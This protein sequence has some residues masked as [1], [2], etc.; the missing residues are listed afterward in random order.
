[1]IFC[2]ELDQNFSTKKEMI[3]ALVAHKQELI[4][5]KKSF[6]KTANNPFFLYKTAATKAA[7]ERELKIGDTVEAVINT[8]LVFDHHQDVHLLGIW[9]KT[10][11]EQSGKIFHLTD[12][13]IRLGSVVGYPKDVTPSVMPLSWRQLRQEADGYTEGLVFN[14]VMTDKTNPDAFKA[15]RDNEPVQHSIRMEYVNLALAVDDP[16][17][18]E[19]YALYQKI[20]P[21]IFNRQDVDEYG[22]FWAVSEAKISR[23]GSI[24][25]FGSNEITP[26]LSKIST[27]F[28]PH[29]G[30]GSEPQKFNVSEAI[31]K[32][33]ILN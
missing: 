25:L 9:N 30:T 28:Q 6:I 16:D 20:Y 3:K 5:L 27:P 33:T 4:G 13:D 7:S 23:E 24:V 11:K 17:M 10:V 26:Q 19:E 32:T 31:S 14:T 15:Y 22:Y 29:K 2:K 21:T 12:H 1:M 18:K 8:C